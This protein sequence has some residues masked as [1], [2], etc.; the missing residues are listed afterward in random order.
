MEG[1]GD[2]IPGVGATRREELAAVCGDRKVGVMRAI[3]HQVE[4]RQNARQRPEDFAHRFPA[5]IAAFELVEETVQA[6]ALEVDR[7]VPGEQVARFREEDDDR[8]HRHPARCAIDLGRGNPVIALGELLQG[9]AVALHQN[10]HGL[11]DALTQHLGEIGLPFAGVTNGLKKG[12]MR[13]PP[14]RASTSSGTVRSVAR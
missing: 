8:T 7:V 12:E 10:L 3:V 1:T 6:I 9:F 5:R 11:P 2:A 4:E 14:P 13:R